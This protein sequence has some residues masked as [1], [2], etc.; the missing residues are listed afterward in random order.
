MSRWLVCAA[1]AC[2]A[3]LAAPAQ[4]PDVPTLPAPRTESGQMTSP[5]RPPAPAAVPERPA[6]YVLPAVDAWAAPP[7]PSPDPLLD[8][9]GAPL[10]GLFVN[11]EP[12][13]VGV[14]FRNQ[15]HIAVPVNA[16]RTDTVQFPGPRLDDA[17]S[18]RVEAGWRLEDGWGDLLVGY[19]FL[20]TQGGNGE[21]AAATGV[22]SAQNSGRLALNS[23]DFAYQS[24][25]FALGPD[26]DMR[27]RTGIRTTFFYYDARLALAEP[28]AG[29]GALLGEGE[30]NYF[31]GIGPLLALELSWKT[32]LP[33]LA[34]FGRIDGG[35]QFG[36]ISQTGAEILAGSA[37]ATEFE[38]TGG[39]E[40]T[41]LSLSEEAGLSYTLPD[42]NY[43]RL[44]L[45]FHYETYFQLGRLNPTGGQ[46]PPPNSRG[47]LDDVGVFLRAEWN[48]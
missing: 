25:E 21:T 14:H 9:P 35:L 22:G 34:V 20:C 10:P 27:W 26:W 36:H 40:V 46:P 2:L 12:D 13:I 32:P 19:R 39:W 33:G 23:F 11:V 47:Q 8:R 43:S 28:A 4:T 24:H 6:A 16:V 5:D 17:L 48:F 41:V 1:V 42:W 30:R 45:G 38:S 7:L 3:A 31:V 29:V 18:M 37:G 15:F 44:M